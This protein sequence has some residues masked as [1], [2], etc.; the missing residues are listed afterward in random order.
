MI[1]IDCI[2]IKNSSSFGQFIAPWIQERNLN[3]SDYLNKTEE[4]DDGIDGIVIFSENQEIDRETEEI[5]NAFDRRQKPVH[6]IDINGTLMVAISNLDVW[7]ESNRCKKVL[8]VG[9]DSLVKN[10]NLERLFTHLH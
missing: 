1:K 5:K 6:K 9:D 10:P 4:A 8:F 7:L 3:S 2:Y